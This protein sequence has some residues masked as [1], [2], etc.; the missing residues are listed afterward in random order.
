MKT[1]TKS[2]VDTQTKLENICNWLAE[3]KGLDLLALDL[4]GK[5]NVAEGIVVA[6]AT[7]MRHAQGLADYVLEKAKE[8]NYEFFQMEGYKSGLWILLDFNDVLVNIFQT[9]QREIYR[10]ED[11]FPGA[12]LV[13]G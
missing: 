5:S 4:A 1:K 9:D 13:R 11:L 2:T 8:S 12:R 3:K 10:L 7:S 6:G